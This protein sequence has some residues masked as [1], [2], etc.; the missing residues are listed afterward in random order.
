MTSEDV[1]M[2]NDRKREVLNELR[3]EMLDRRAARLN[4]WLQV[5]GLVLTFFAVGVAVVGILGFRRFEELELRARDMLERVEDRASDSLARVERHEEAAG[6]L[7]KKLD[8]LAE[9]LDLAQP[10]QNL[11]GAAVTLPEAM[12]PGLL[13]RTA[14]GLE[15]FQA[16]SG[17]LEDGAKERRSFSLPAGDFW[18]AGTCD[19][20]CVDLDLRLYETDT[21]EF[22]NEDILVD[23]VPL[24]RHQTT[25]PVDLELDVL[26]VDCLSSECSWTVT[27]YG[28][29][30]ED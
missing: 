17:S 10:T 29:D 20:G 8:Q 1:S 25:E 7:R 18:F 11:G 24:L 22:L 14:M 23:D 3:G 6:D 9:D 13:L 27:V 19:V 16:V 28:R 2:N 4:R 21:G 12:G 30:G 5:V 26:M 15:E